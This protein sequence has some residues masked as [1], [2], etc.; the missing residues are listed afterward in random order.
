MEI[1]FP[2]PIRVDRLQIET[3]ADNPDIRLQLEEM[4]AS[5]RW[6]PLSSKP[7]DLTRAPENSLRRAAAYELQAQGVR[8]LLVRDGEPSAASYADDPASWNFS[9]AARSPGAIIYK[10]GRE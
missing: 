3:S 2:S 5:G 6:T 4:D 1:E 9:I 8:Y 7:Q 10:V